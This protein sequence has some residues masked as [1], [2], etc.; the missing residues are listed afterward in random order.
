MERK[1]TE[2]A[3]ES[4]LV[5]LGRLEHAGLVEETRTCTTCRQ[6]LPARRGE[7]TAQ[8]HCMLFDLPLEPSDLRVDCAEHERQVAV[9]D[10]QVEVALR[11]L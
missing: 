3:L 4:L 6:F 1:H 2:Q 7:P 10:S 5:L 11:P 9:D 8:H